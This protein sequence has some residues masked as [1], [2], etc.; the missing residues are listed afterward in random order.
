M[1]GSPRDQ[2]KPCHLPHHDI[3]VPPAQFESPQDALPLYA[4]PALQQQVENMAGGKRDTTLFFAGALPELQQEG[5]WGHKGSGPGEAAGRALV[6]GRLGSGREGAGLGAQGG[7]ASQHHAEPS[8]QA[9]TGAQQAMAHDSAREQAQ[10]TCTPV[11]LPPTHPPPRRRQPGVAGGVQLR[12]APDRGA[13]L[14]RP[15]WL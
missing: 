2:W 4:N 3:V 13:P 15:P 6:G 8:L 9:R 12:R 14:P 11:P 10:H 5:G 7:A 1:A